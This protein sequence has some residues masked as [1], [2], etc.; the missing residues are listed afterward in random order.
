[1]NPSTRR[2]SRGACPA[3]RGNDAR[4]DVEDRSL[5]PIGKDGLAAVGRGWEDVVAEV[6][7]LSMG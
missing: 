7:R 4:S 5:E 3:G 6:E 2:S 1:M